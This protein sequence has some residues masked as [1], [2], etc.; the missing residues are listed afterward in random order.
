[1]HPCSKCDDLASPAFPANMCNNHLICP[2]N[3]PST[4][5]SIFLLSYKLMFQHFDFYPFRICAEC[6]VEDVKE[7]VIVC[8]EVD[9]HK[10]ASLNGT[11]DNPV[12]G[13]LSF[14]KLCELN[15]TDICEVKANQCGIKF[16]YMKFGTAHDKNKEFIGNI[17]YL[18]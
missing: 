8:R 17:T 4:L 6:K 18:G 5:Q 16:P 15:N 9:P 11:L 10:R 7:H 2:Q 14:Y 12:P 13:L 1:M 3:G